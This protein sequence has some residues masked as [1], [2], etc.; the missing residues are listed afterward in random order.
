MLIRLIA[1]IIFS[2]FIFNGCKGKAFFL[3]CKQNNTFFS[4][5]LYFVSKKAFP[6]TDYK[7][8]GTSRHEPVF[9]TSGFAPDEKKMSLVQKKNLTGAKTKYA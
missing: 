4:Q 9:I 7:N 5:K 1:F 2:C 3:T 6:E 8:C